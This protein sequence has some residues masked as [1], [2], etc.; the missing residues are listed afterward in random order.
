M[1]FGWGA[2]SKWDIIATDAANDTITIAGDIT[3]ILDMDDS[4]SIHNSD[5][6]DGDYD[7]A[8]WTADAVSTT[9]TLA[10]PG[11]SV[12]PNIES[13]GYFQLDNVDATDWYQYVIVEANSTTNTFTVNG[14]PATNV[15]PGMEF[16]VFGTTNDGIYQA[17]TI[18]PFDVATNTTEIGV[19]SIANDE[20]GGWIESYRDYGI[21]IVLEDTIGVA[22][23]E[24]ATSALIQTGGSLIDGFD[25][26]YFDVGSLDEDVVTVRRLYGN[27]FT[28]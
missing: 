8:S 11:L 1:T 5:G 21:R 19:A 2:I 15:M 6:N 17:L 16:R 22:V 9:I 10:A 7:I 23:A 3:G 26:T 14:N 25:Y 13:L 28:S 24:E 12:D 27:T 4:G 20:T 18:S